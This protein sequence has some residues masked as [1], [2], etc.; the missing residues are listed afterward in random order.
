M[1]H[2]L[3]QITSIHDSIAT[4]R[5]GSQTHNVITIYPRD[6]ST[7]NRTTTCPVIIAESPTRFRA[8]L[9]LQV[10]TNPSP[11]TSK[12]P[13]GYR[14]FKIPRVRLVDYLILVRII[15]RDLV[16]RLSSIWG[17]ALR[18]GLAWVEEGHCVAH[19][20][21]QGVEL[22]IRLCELERGQTKKGTRI[23]GCF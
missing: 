16:G 13:R 5:K 11:S 1:G 4:W 14:D 3:A 10:A 22:S 20:R 21:L 18:G 8:F 23:I 6:M 17:C 9:S 2:K 19:H 15:S 12:S 7:P